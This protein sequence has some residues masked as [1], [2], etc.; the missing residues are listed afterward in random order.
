MSRRRNVGGIDRILRVAFGTIL[1]PAGLMLAA[2]GHPFAWTVTIIGGLLL[3]SGVLGFCPP[4]SVLGISTA[5]PSCSRQ[6]GG[7]V[8]DRSVR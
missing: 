6:R 7:A 8:K 3:A 1:L 4:Y 5:E 2:G